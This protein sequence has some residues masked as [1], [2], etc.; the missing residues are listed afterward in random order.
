MGQSALRPRAYLRH[1]TDIPIRVDALPI[2]AR[3]A[4]RMKDVGLGGLSCRANSELDVGTLVEISIDVVS[5]PFHAEGRVAW[6]ETRNG[7]HE[8]GIQFTR[9][10]DA[11]AARMVEQICYI[12]QYRNDVLLKEGRVIDSNTAAHEWIQQHAAGFPS[13]SH[14][15]SSTS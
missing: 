4:H 9:Q 12:E 10:E 15:R 6:C 11:F 2:Q 3:S 1:P 14:F 8:L 5:P 7:I 13:L